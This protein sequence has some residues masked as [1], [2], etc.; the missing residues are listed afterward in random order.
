MRLLLSCYA[1]EPNAGSESGNGWNWAWHLAASGAEVVLLTL[2][3]HRA[4]I[5]EHLA[6]QPAPPDLTISYVAVPPLVTRLARGQLGVYGTYL[7]W[8]WAALRHARRL[9]GARPFDLVHHLTW[10]SLKLGSWLWR[11]GTPFV[12][13]PVGGGQTAPSHLREFYGASFASEAL[14]SVVTRYLMRANPFAILAAR[15]ASL[16][17]VNNDATAALAARLGARRIRYCSEIGVDPAGI[18]PGVPERPADGPLRLVWVGRMLP[19][20]AL[21]LALRAVAAVPPDVEVRLTV[22]GSG[23]LAAQ[24]EGWI[25][26]LGIGDRVEL[27]GQVPYEEVQR[28]YRTHDALLFTSLRDSTGAPLLEAASAALP[29]ICLD[30]HGAARLVSDDAGIKVPVGAADEVVRGVADAITLLAGDRPLLA[31]KSKAALDVAQG[32][33]WPRKAEEMRRHY[34]EVLR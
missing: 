26:D 16:V 15:R 17:L 7:A 9:A 31:A 11:L 4:P 1:C 22:V 8:Q 33:A 2:D 25:A 24:V 12:F 23:P 5:E 19:L 3:E 30:H 21:P 6:R 27:T 20:K 28:V 10:G 13:G 34:E 32:E 18:L 14:R 29:V